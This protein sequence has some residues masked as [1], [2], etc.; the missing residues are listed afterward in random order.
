MTDRQMTY[1]EL[2]TA[3][4]KTPDAARQLVKRKRWKRTIGNDGK[5]RITVPDDE[6]QP[7]ASPRCPPDDRPDDRPDTV[8]IL[9]AHIERLE[10]ELATVRAERDLLR[11]RADAGAIATA[12]VEALGMLLA[13]ARRP[14]WKRLAG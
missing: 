11:D 10:T 5:A 3:L 2:A 7:D 12:Q 4:D 13:E 8:T 14:W 1:D 9:T 6:L